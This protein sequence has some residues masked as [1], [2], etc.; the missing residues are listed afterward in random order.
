MQRNTLVQLIVIY[1]GILA[2]YAGIS[3]L[4]PVVSAAFTHLV[5][6]RGTGNYFEIIYLISFILFIAAGYIIIAKSGDISVFISDRSGLD[7]SL[8]IY[9]KPSQLLSILIVVIALAHLL[10]YTPKLFHDLYQLFTGSTDGR[11]IGYQGKLLDPPQLFGNFLH[12]L[13][14][15]LMIIFCRNLTVYFSKNILLGENEIIAD[16]ETV[17]IE[18]PDTQEQV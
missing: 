8:K 11:L 14:A 10:D 1:I 5:A 13:I 17:T 7:D 16:H 9:T 15:C 12:V 2:I 6:D 3:Y 4:I 18:E